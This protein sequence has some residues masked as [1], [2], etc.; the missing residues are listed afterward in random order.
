MSTFKIIS[1]IIGIILFPLAASAG[2]PP[3]GTPQMNPVNGVYYQCVRGCGTWFEARDFAETQL[4]DGQRGHLAVITTEQEQQFISGDLD[5]GG[6]LGG[7]QSETA[8]E[9]DEGWAWINGEPFVFT[10]WGGDEPNDSGCDG[11][12]GCEN[13]LE[14]RD[15]WNDE[16]CQS[17]RNCIIQ[18]APIE[19]RPIPVLSKW[20]IVAMAAVFGVIGFI[21]LRRKAAV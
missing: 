10:A 3:P 8:T 4:F 9:P 15:E 2:A 17:E 16:N 18:F 1:F 14:S 5:C 19:P 6:W 20:G 13:C 21:A 11:E 7:F 12:D